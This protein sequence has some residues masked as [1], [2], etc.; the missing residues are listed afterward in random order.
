MSKRTKHDFT[1][2]RT[3][4]IDGIEGDYARVELPDGTTE[5]WRLDGL[6]EGVQEGDIVKVHAAEGTFQMQID[7][8]ETS[9]RRAQAQHHLDALN[10]A[11]TTGEIDL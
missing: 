10:A 3:V 6:P 4:T 2:A 8:E 5:D 11:P 1:H 7:H 9:L